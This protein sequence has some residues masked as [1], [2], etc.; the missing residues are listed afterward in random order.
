LW[1]CSLVW[2]SISLQRHSVYLGH[3]LCYWLVQEKYT[4][5]FYILDCSYT[6]RFSYS[7]SHSIKL[8]YFFLCELL[9]ITPL[10]APTISSKSRNTPSIT[11]KEPFK[12]CHVHRMHAPFW[13][14]V[15][16]KFQFIFLTNGTQNLKLSDLDMPWK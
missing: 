2:S 4:I 10:S 9:V 16:T 1:T 11:K 15:I 12:K 5:L 8:S 13:H 6:K 3:I 14:S 7:L